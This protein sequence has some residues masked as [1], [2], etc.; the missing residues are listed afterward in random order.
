[1]D[2]PKKTSKRHDFAPDPNQSVYQ[3]AIV[4][5][6]ADSSSSVSVENTWVFAVMSESV[7]DSGRQRLSVLG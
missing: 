1:M 5:N 4:T 6:L 3:I 2:F 7:R